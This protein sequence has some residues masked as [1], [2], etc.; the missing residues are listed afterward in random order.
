[1]KYPITMAFTVVRN[2][3][4]NHSSNRTLPG[5]DEFTTLKQMIYSSRVLNDQFPPVYLKNPPLK[6]VL[7]QSDCH[8]FVAAEP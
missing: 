1:M 5:T 6:V 4:K 8:Y 7:T 2:I 3:K